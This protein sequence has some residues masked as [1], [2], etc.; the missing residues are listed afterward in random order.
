MSSGTPKIITLF[1]I[2]PV[3][4]SFSNLSGFPDLLGFTVSGGGDG[5]S[6]PP[7][8]VFHDARVSHSPFLSL[9]LGEVAANTP[10]RVVDL[11]ATT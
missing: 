2:S 5:P 6:R 4:L 8:I 11:P 9:L 3:F 7:A 10:I 1:T